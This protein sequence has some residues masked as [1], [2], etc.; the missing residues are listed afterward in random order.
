LSSSFLLLFLIISLLPAAAR[1]YI[2]N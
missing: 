2:A 1:S